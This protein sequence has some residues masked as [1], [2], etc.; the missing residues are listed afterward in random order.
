MPG[1]DLNAE[2]DD[3]SE[4]VKAAN[5]KLELAADETRDWAVADVA[6]AEDKTS[7]AV[8]R[9]KKKVETTHST[10]SEHREE[11]LE[12]RHAHDAGDRNDVTDGT[13][14]ADPKYPATT[15]DPIDFADPSVD[16][17]Q[18]GVLDALD[19]RGAPET[20]AS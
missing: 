2:F 13:A 11:A 12:Q 20:P 14:G 19:T 17:A 6:I 3:M 8:D 9:L 5:D 18:E 7:E 16:E 1:F 15:P 10:A 4:K